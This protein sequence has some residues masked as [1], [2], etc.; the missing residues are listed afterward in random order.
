MKVVKEIYGRKQTKDGWHA[1][2]NSPFS[3]QLLHFL[4]VTTLLTMVTLQ[5]VHLVAGPSSCL[6]A[7]LNS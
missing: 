5:R 2:Y 3:R 6:R 1:D 7:I 4:A